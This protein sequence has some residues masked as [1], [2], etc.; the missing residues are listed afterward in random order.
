MAQVRIYNK[1]IYDFEQTYRGKKWKIPAGESILAEESEGREFFYAWTPVIKDNKGQ[2]DERYLK[3]L[4]IEYLKRKDKQPV[5]DVLNCM[6]CNLKFESD[7]ELKAHTL[8]Q[9]KQYL[10]DSETAQ[11]LET[12]INTALN[13][14]PKKKAGRKKK[15]V[16]KKTTE[17]ANG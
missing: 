1:N 6:V 16:R 13:P 3:K 12:E 15:V 14:P 10:A 4:E 9:H 8:A 17:E 7:L 11:E 5:K 2:A